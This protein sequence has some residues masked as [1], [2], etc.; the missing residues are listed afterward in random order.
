ML[1][2]TCG[3]SSLDWLAAKLK[4]EV[5]W[6]SRFANA[7]A[8]PMR[9]FFRGCRSALKYRI[10]LADMSAEGCNTQRTLILLPHSVAR[11]LSHI[12]TW[13]VRVPFPLTT[14]AG[15]PDRCGTQLVCRLGLQGTCLYECVAAVFLQPRIPEVVKK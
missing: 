1:A 9:H 3:R 2:S 14:P 8:E 6:R 10:H 11:R 12:F 4:P 7:V 15:C 13:Q 5:G